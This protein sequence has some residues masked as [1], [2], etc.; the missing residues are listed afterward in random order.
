MEREKRGKNYSSWALIQEVKPDKDGKKTHFKTMS[1]YFLT[2]FSYHVNFSF[3]LGEFVTDVQL[4]IKEIFLAKGLKQE[5]RAMH[6]V[7]S[8]REVYSFIKLK[9]KKKILLIRISKLKNEISMN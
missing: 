3:K 9:Y 8:V 1:F 4:P 5:N 2:G 6:V 7:T